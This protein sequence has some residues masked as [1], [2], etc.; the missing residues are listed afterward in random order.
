MK[1]WRRTAGLVGLALGLTLPAY[2]QTL[3]NGDFGTGD[4]SGWSAETVNDGHVS[5]VRQGIAFSKLPGSERIPFPDGPG[6]YAADLRV[7]SA[8]PPQ[9]AAIL[10]SAP[11]TP[12]SDRL[13]FL[14][15]SENASVA[16][17]VL[18][19]TA[20]AD[21]L[22]PSVSDILLL[23]DVVRDQPGTGES[24]KFERQIVDVSAPFAAKQPIRVQFRQTA[25]A[26][27]AGFFTLIADVAD[28]SPDTVAPDA[29]ADLSAA[30]T[31]PSSVTLT[32][33]APKDSGTGSSGGAASYDV[34]YSFFP[35][36]E[37]N[38][39]SATRF[40]RPPTP[41]PAGVIERFDVSGLDPV[42]TYY[43]AV[44]S[45]DAAKNAG[46]ISN[47]VQATTTAST[48]MGRVNGVALDASGAPA[49][50]FSLKLTSETGDVSGVVTD[51]SGAFSLLLP[52]GAYR[53][54][55][56]T[57]SSAV[58]SS[59]PPV[60]VTA[61]AVT[62]AP[63]ITLGP[64]EIRGLG[65]FNGN[66]A[67]GDL[68]GWTPTGYDG[69]LVQPERNGKQYFGDP[70]PYPDGGDS[71]AVDV[72]SWDDP[73]QLGDTASTGILV[74]DPFLPNAA[75]L[76][77]MTHSQAKNV[78]P[79]LLLLK[80][81][82]DPIRPKPDEIYLLEN[83]RNDAPGQ[84]SQYRFEKQTVDLSKFYN[85][86]DPSQGTPMRL[87]VRQHTTEPGFGWYTLFTDFNAGPV[88]SVHAPK[89][90]VNG[91]GRVDIG[92]AT[93]ALKEVLGLLGPVTPA[94][95][96]AADVAPKRSDGSYGDGQL[97]VSDVT[98]L[99]RRAVGLDADPWP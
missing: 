22:N 50:N 19:L 8:G 47:V 26:N 97:L 35:L 14:T 64:L 85:P 81:T 86:S 42:R 25:T 32:F 54:S 55:G 92:D 12:R 56:Q 39:G 7:D 3:T 51:G 24:A 61:N 18:V 60:L 21:P 17:Q 5:V 46:P 59:T 44:K 95:I 28:L 84:G 80:R 70:V 41:A 20:N 91:D 65:I 68:T 67:D 82:A 83:V 99:L 98:R 69:G 78:A 45:L 43:F 1:R 23:Q 6:G 58:P 72:R 13:Y 2:G 36:T 74:S 33:A 77:F 57:L 73:L 75:T 34:R 79:Q 38:F 37:A 66:F 90:D 10:T 88:A 49:A 15:L 62:V 40:D 87:E 96:R 63:P 94:M 52:P 16:P 31:A 30:K 93:L 89:G 48:P 29:I 76:T 71:W 4:L 9:G 27:G 11:F 53:F